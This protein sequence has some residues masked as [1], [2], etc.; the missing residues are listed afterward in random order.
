MLTGDISFLTG[1]R[2]GV[3]CPTFVSDGRAGVGYGHHRTVGLQ[4]AYWSRQLRS[5][6]LL[7][8]KHNG[9]SGGLFLFFPAISSME[10][11]PPFLIGAATA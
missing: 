9:P 10:Q 7:K 11:M 3:E 5:L 1:L 6:A 2:A 8:A 4:P